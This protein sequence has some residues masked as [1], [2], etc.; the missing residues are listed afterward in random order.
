MFLLSV[1][2]EL[3]KF[4][5]SRQDGPQNETVFEPAAK[6][7]HTMESSPK[8]YNYTP[9][10]LSA[11]VASQGIPQKIITMATSS[12]TNLPAPSE[13]QPWN[14]LVDDKGAIS[15][16]PADVVSKF[17]RTYPSVL[18]C[19]HFTTPTMT[20]S[21][22]LTTSRTPVSWSGLGSVSNTG[23]PSSIIIT[24][25][26]LKTQGKSPAGIKSSSLHKPMKWTLTLDQEEVKKRQSLQ[27]EKPKK[28][29][30]N[31]SHLKTCVT[32]LM[33][34]NPG[35]TSSMSNT[36]GLI[37]PA[38]KRSV[39][40]TG[41]PRS[42]PVTESAASRVKSATHSLM[43]ERRVN[44]FPYNQQIILSKPCAP[45]DSLK[46]QPPGPR[47]SSGT[48][49]NG[50][51]R[52]PI[53]RLQ[54]FLGEAPH[55]GLSGEATKAVA[56]SPSGIYPTI[57]KSLQS[58][59]KA[60]HPKVSKVH[61]VSYEC[62]STV[63]T[64]CTGTTTTCRTATAGSTTSTTPASGTGS[65]GSMI[66]GSS[67][68][69]AA[70]MARAGH[71]LSVISEPL[72]LSTHSRISAVSVSS[73]AGCK[74]NP[75]IGLPQKGETLVMKGKKY[76]VEDPAKS[77][78]EGGFREQEDGDSDSDLSYLNILRLIPLLKWRIKKKDKFRHIC[79]MSQQKDDVWGE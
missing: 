74:T 8:F 56:A 75:S 73:S 67:T 39:T 31:L 14:L 17:P 40:V 58:G 2:D 20:P 34:T 9:P 21:V 25:D 53:L 57:A 32:T 64:A 71:P 66:A 61:A 70:N 4:D 69:P 7:A 6:K 44:S 11:Y 43:S 68:T 13:G 26:A 76:M 55:S 46:Q 65:V 10:S 23:K 72:D 77:I 59:H 27:N 48:R 42:V 1:S 38:R 50:Q 51:G 28:E 12:S 29:T 60:L 19:G 3:K 30:K 41:I 18:S 54:R 52:L 49:P 45:Q 24:K 22:R 62:D 78:V 5:S 33:K 36:S 79:H 37:T 16:T 47:A 35:V 63:S 15:L